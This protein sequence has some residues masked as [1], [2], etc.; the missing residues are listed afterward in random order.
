MFTKTSLTQYISKNTVITLK[1]LS[2][3]WYEQVQRHTCDIAIQN[4]PFLSNEY[5]FL[6]LE[7]VGVT[8]PSDKRKIFTCH[9]SCTT[10]VRSYMLERRVHIMTTHWLAR[11]SRDM[12]VFF[13]TSFPKPFC[14]AYV[15]EI[16][17]SA[18]ILVDY[19]RHQG[20]GKFVF[21]SEARGQSSVCLEN[22]FQ[23]G[24]RNDFLKT[25]YHTVLYIPWCGT[26]E[27]KNDQHFLLRYS[28][29]GNLLFIP[30]LEKTEDAL[31]DKF[32]GVSVFGE[33][34]F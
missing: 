22:D 20:L 3:L 13:Q 18:S 14:R 15:T 12:W 23:I 28:M 33:N 1:N 4:R 16:A 26:Q 34:S 8:V 17:L 5:T 31:V 32:G 2:H 19:T 11:A 7:K 27:W 30:F 10:S 9:T 6:Y 24:K 29:N 25:T 21:E